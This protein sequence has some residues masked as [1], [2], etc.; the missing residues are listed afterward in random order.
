MVNN[1]TQTN[2]K[3]IRALK[4]VVLLTLAI[5]AMFGTAHA[6]DFSAVAPSGQTLYYN[7]IIISG[8]AQVTNPNYGS[9]YPWGG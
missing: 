7:I 3:E 5:V 4:K 2:M 8:G 9:N 1:W 6:Y